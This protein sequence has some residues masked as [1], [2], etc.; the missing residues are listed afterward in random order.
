M[1]LLADGTFLRYS[2]LRPVYSLNILGYPHFSGDGDAL[3]IFTLYDRKRNRTFDKEYITIAFFELAKSHVET[4]NQRHWMSY[5]KTGEAPEG[6][7]EYIKKAA[8][9]IEMANLTQEERDVIDQIER[10]EEI[11]KNTIYSAQIEGERIGVAKGK[12]EGE[13]IGEAN[14][15]IEE[16]LAIARNMLNNNRPVDMIVEDTGLTIDEIRKL[17]H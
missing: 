7:P 6:A 13:R 12:I 10:A 2:S 16:R 11:Y 5:F 9:V 14:G 4:E 1:K 8:W 3:R 17:V 15:K